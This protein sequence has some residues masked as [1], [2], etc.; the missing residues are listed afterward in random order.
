MNDT[1]LADV[2][3]PMRDGVRLATEVWIP[4][5]APAPAL[6]LR[7][8]YG[9]DMTPEVTMAPRR[10]ALVDAGYVVVWQD[11]RG[12][13]RSEGEGFEPFVAEAADGEDTIAWL[14]EQP[15][16]DGRIGMYGPSYMGCVQWQAA[17]TGAPGLLA[18]APHFASTD[19]FKAPWFSAGG[20]MSWHL[21]HSWSMLQSAVEG[22]AGFTEGGLEQVMARVALN[23]AYLDELPMSERPVITDTGAA[24][25]WP[26]WMAHTDH[27]G[28]WRAIAAAPAAASVTTPALHVVGW[29]DLYADESVASY[30]LMR[31]LAATEEAR[32]GQ[33][34]VIGPWD[35]AS[36][37]GVYPHRDF[38]TSAS[39]AACGIED[40]HLRFFDQ[41]LRGDAEALAD[42]APVR[43][44]V[45]GA[46]TWRDEEAWPL[47]DTDYREF[48]LAG[49]DDASRATGGT[50]SPDPSSSDAADAF[51][52]DPGNPV[53]SAGGR[54]LV[55]GDPLGCGPVDQSAVEE[56]P[57]VLCFTTPALESD[58]E[59]TGHVSLVLYVTS[60]A[61]DTDVTG[62]LVDVHPDGRALYLTDGILRMRYRH[63]LERPEPMVPGEVHEVRIDLGVTSN[64]FREGHRLRLEIS[65]S[66]YPRYDRN[67]NTGGHIATETAFQI[68][69][70]AVLHGPSAPSRLILPIIDRG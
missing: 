47:P 10:Q 5:G 23:D 29:F 46:D 11:V 32:A 50:L 18:L 52:S 49:P 22:M 68:A 20:A 64:V 53:P 14:V 21:V 8:P 1:R 69:H 25:W 13:F 39:A 24:A 42:D 36:Q 12:R 34:L 61:L 3:V 67:T 35:H 56:R 66:N 65:S 9:K 58:L 48:H 7:L 4:D 33:R 70:N 41:H 17:T 6:L 63:S 31:E 54:M 30:R 15:W 51:L 19:V 40:L 16:C 57:D 62:K 2:M 59:V 28:Y 26:K 45:M 55:V 43:I 44:F 27:D 38:G 37:S 60:T